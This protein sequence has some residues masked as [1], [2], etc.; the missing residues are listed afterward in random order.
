LWEDP[1]DFHLS[2]LRSGDSHAIVGEEAHFHRYPTHGLVPHSRAKFHWAITAC[3]NRQGW[4]RA[5]A[6]TLVSAWSSGVLPVSTTVVWC[7]HYNASAIPSLFYDTRFS[8]HLRI[9]YLPE[10][11][12]APPNSTVSTRV[13]YMRA[14]AMADYL[15]GH[16]QPGGLRVPASRRS[17]LPL[18]IT[19]DDIVFVPDF[20]ARLSQLLM[21]VHQTLGPGPG[22]PAFMMTLYNPGDVQPVSTSLE[23][24]HTK[25]STDPSRFDNK[26]ASESKVESFPWAF[27][28]GCAG[29]LFSPAMAR[30]LTH[31]FS[32]SLKNDSAYSQGSAHRAE[33]LQDTTIVEFTWRIYHCRTPKQWDD[34]R[35][36]PRGARD[37]PTCVVFR[38]LPSLVEHVGISSSLFGAV[39]TNKKFHTSHDFPFKV[40][41]PMQDPPGTWRRRRRRGSSRRS[42]AAMLR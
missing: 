25:W 8:R 37:R 30:A 24:Y 19:E 32:L 28:F 11:M 36:G 14:L 22:R 26:T 20:N 17:G 42:R 9:M 23:R 13:Q 40:A 35:A 29:V 5:L 7:R 10:D 41:F 38:T 16:D 31:H 18:L 15:A 1:S 12:P 27:N 2:S 39:A 4:A 6:S 3:D 34:W 33:L 21:D